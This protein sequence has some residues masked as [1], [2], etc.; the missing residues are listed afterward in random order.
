[1]PKRIVEPVITRLPG[2]AERWVLE[3][4]YT[5]VLPIVHR[6]L[7]VLAGFSFDGLS[8]PRMFYRILHPLEA[9]ASA[10]CHDALYCSELLPRRQADAILRELLRLEGCSWL[11][12]NAA[13]AAVRMFGWL[14]WR[15]HTSW[16]GRRSRRLISLDRPPP[17]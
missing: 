5:I 3:R 14:V 9:P 17:Q 2:A 16:S 8:V 7:F 13:Y 10:V 4:D 11:Q 15:K 6:E 1:M 12:A